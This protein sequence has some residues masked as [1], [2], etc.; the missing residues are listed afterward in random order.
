MMYISKGRVILFVILGFLLGLMTHCSGHIEKDSQKRPNVSQK[1]MVV[2]VDKQAQAAEL[3]VKIYSE[4]SR[5]GASPSRC[6]EQAR[7][8]AITIY[9]VEK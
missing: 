9:G 1:T 3:Y 5:Q 2:P 7:Q 6:E 8:A 4:V